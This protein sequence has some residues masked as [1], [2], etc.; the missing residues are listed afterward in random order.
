MRP[1]SKAAVLALGLLGTGRGFKATILA[2]T[3]RDGRVD[4]TGDTDMA[5][6]QIWTDTRGALFLANIGDTQQRCSVHITESVSDHDLDKCHDASDNV[7]RNAKY[8][9]P[10]K[11]VPCSGLSSAATGRLFVSGLGAADRVRIFRKFH[12]GWV[13]VASDYV[14][15]ARDLEAGLDLGIDGRDVRRPGV[16]DGRVKVHLVIRDGAEI[17]MDAVALRVAPVLTHHHLQLASQVLVTGAGTRSPQ[18][19]FVQDLQ[20]N[21]KKAGIE[22]PVYQFPGDDIW[23]QD[24]FEPGYMSIPGPHGAIMLR[25]MIRSS[26]GGRPTGRMVFSMLRSDTVGA[27][28]FLGNDWGDTTDSMGNLET[29]PPHTHN[30]KS[31]PAGRTIVGSRNGLRPYMTNFLNAQE[32]QATVNVDTGFLLIGHVDEFLQFL[33]AKNARGW[34]MMVNDP[35]AGFEILQ[36]TKAAG[37][38]AIK[39]LSRPS[40]P[41]DKSQ[42]L[43]SDTVDE[44]LRRG[45]RTVNFANAQAYSALRIQ[46]NVDIIKRETG[47]EDADIIRVPTLFYT[48]SFECSCN[49]EDDDG[50]ED[51]GGT[52]VVKD[53][54][55]A[56]GPRSKTRTPRRRKLQDALFTAFY[57]GSIN[58][59]V[60]SDTQVLA[61]NP[62]G[63]VVNGKD[64]IAEA[65]AAAYRKVGYTVIFQEDWFSHHVDQGDV[66]CG[67]NTI[68]NPTTPWW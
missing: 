68:R 57:P 32:V 41:S 61:P 13:Y 62:W 45:D 5:D 28:Q 36:K 48:E 15:S 65:V 1:I 34:V 22:W 25:V 30:G 67:T 47:L 55:E 42:C 26:Q 46:A 2:D 59:V 56:A 24:F 19:K 6:K 39:A 7:Q 49:G 43:P 35:M 8:L 66:H 17:A 50:D 52:L 53:I 29:I 16:W 9:A 63:P 21:V 27:V 40:F 38:G 64:I 4:V 10:L 51:N 31:Y 54:V 14:F 44:V 37:L 23:T 11:S 58:G 20:A 18:A 12:N 33:P 60:L 3:N